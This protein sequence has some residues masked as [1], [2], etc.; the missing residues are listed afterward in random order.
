MYPHSICKGLVA[1]NKDASKRV[2][3]VQSTSENVM[4]AYHMDKTYIPLLEDACLH[5]VFMCLS[6]FASKF[7]IPNFNVQFCL[8]TKSF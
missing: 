6:S 1:N 2:F 8:L 4:D 5:I 7:V 3:L